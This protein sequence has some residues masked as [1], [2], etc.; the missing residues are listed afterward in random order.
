LT[1]SEPRNVFSASR[2][3]QIPLR[4]PGRRAGRSPVSDQVSE[5]FARVCD[6]LATFLKAG[7]R[8]VRA[9]STCRDSS[10]LVAVRFAVG[11]RPAFDRPATHT[12]HAHAGLRPGLRPGLRLDGVMEFDLNALKS[13]DLPWIPSGERRTTKPE[14][15]IRSVVPIP[16]YRLTSLMMM[17]MIIMTIMTIIIMMMKLKLEAKDVLPNI[18][19]TLKATSRKA[20]K[21]RFCFP[22]VPGD[23]DL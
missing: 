13:T 23:L 9:I 11:F 14:S 16:G 8:Q 20:P 12:R 15:L 1:F 17:M 6:Q 10:N 22:F 3:G 2:K 18:N 19:H 21:C 5:K 4:Y 7:R